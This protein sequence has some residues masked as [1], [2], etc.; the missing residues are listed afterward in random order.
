M[1]IIVAGAAAI[2]LAA[3]G[4]YAQ[5]NGKGNG[6]GNKHAAGQAKGNGNGGKKADRGPDRQ[7]KGQR[8]QK[9]GNG[10]DNRDR[11]WEGRPAQAQNDKRGN[12]R[13]DE[14]NERSYDDRRADRN[15]RRDDRREVRVRYDDRDRRDGHRILRGERDTRWLVQDRDRTLIDGCP[16]GLAKKRNGCNPPGQVKDRYQRNLFGYDYRPSLFGLT[17]YDRRGDYYYNDGY[18]VRYGDRG[19][20]SWI[21]LLGGALGIGNVWP[22]GYESYR[23]PDYYVD[24]YNLGSPDRYRYADNVIY[25]VAPEDAAITSIAALITG[26]DFRI[27][28]AMPRG[29]DVYNVPHAYRDRY[30]DTPDYM[31]RY[32][33][34]YVYQIDPETRLVAAAIELLI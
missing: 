33:D 26:D 4:A 13:R 31:Y 18:L 27:G 22:R 24:Y 34:G 29:Y 20:S 17:N 12:G 21:P 6:G 9:K 1:R 30:Y 19:V 32:S 2:A 15:D 25:R 16:P 7:E 14:R 11:D 10:R 3:S 23:V 28:Q 8:A 5:G